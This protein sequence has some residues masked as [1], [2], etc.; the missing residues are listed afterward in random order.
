VLTEIR[1]RGVKDVL[2]VCSD[3]LSGFPE[4]IDAVFPQAVNQTCIVHLV[5][6][7][8]RYLS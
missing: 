7:S 8:L 5:R 2:L 6:R 3:G 4:A 1:N